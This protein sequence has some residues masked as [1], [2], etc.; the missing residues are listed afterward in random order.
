MDFI[1]TEKLL[2]E[3]AGCSTSHL[4]HIKQ[5]KRTVSEDLAEKLEGITGISKWSWG[6]ASA[7][8]LHISVAKYIADQREQEAIA[9]RRAA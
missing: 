2:A 4:S 7:K 1:T 5:R 3:A 6:T 9:K 8:T